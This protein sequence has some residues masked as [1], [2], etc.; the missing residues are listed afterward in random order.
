M[1]IIEVDYLKVLVVFWFFY[2]CIYNVKIV[3]K[4]NFIKNM[5]F[6]YL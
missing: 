3:L 6:K 4:Y 5:K 2:F 1:Y